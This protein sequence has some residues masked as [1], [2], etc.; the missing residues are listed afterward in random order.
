MK[1]AIVTG[2]NGFVGRYLVKNLLDNDYKVWAVVRN[3]RNICKTFIEND[4][5][6]IIVCDLIN[7]NIL[8]TLFAEKDFNCFY[9]LAWE[10]SSGDLRK[11]Y[12]VQLKNVKASSD[13]IKVAKILNCK[14]FVGA[15]SV[16]ELMYRDYLQIDNSKPEM[17]TCYAIGKI[18]SEYL[19]RCLCVEYG[20]DFIWGYLSNFYGRGDTT[21]NFVNFIMLS[22]MNNIIPKLTEGNQLADFMY[23][24][25]IARALRLLGEKGVNGKSYYVGYADPKPLKDYV[26]KIRNLI[27]PKIET[28]LNKKVFRGLNID[29]DK[30]DIE[31]IYKDTGFKPSVSFDEGIKLTFDWL[32]EEF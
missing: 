6:N 2:A 27:N 7:Y 26:V 5:V 23:V 13:A 1:K 11:N 16:T 14:R 28:G 20:I 32:K 4:N 30:I 19:C 17:V 12:E 10:G 3:K 22:Y 15:G 31:K 24:S 21:K 9:H 18:A 25:D 29:F 8:D